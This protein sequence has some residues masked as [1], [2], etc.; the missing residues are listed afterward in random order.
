MLPCP[1]YREGQAS[2]PNPSPYKRNNVRTDDLSRKLLDREL[3]TMRIL[4]VAEHNGRPQSP[5][6]P[7]GLTKQP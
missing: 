1:P 3:L 5:A 2:Q 4:I 6:E 7:A